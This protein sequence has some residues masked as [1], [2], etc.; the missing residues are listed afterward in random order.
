ML[1][2]ISHG[3]ASVQTGF[4]NKARKGKG[5]QQKVEPEPDFGEPLEEVYDKG[6]EWDYRKAKSQALKPAIEQVLGMKYAG[7]VSLC[8]TV[9]KLR[10]NKETGELGVRPQESCRRRWCPICEWRKSLKRWGILSE[11]LP[12]LIKQHGPVKWIFL[13]LT[14]RNCAVDDLPN[15]VSAMSKGFRNLTNNKTAL[16]RSWPGKAWIKSLE[17]TFPRPGE[18]HPHYHVLIAVKPS[19][20]KGGNYIPQKEWAERWQKAM[21][22]D[23]TPVVDVRRVKPLNQGN[24]SEADQQ[25]AEAM[26]GVREV[27]KYALEPVDIDAGNPEAIRGLASLTSYRFVDCGGWLKGVFR[28]PEND[29]Q[30][31]KPEMQNV[32]EFWWRA[33][34]MIYRRKLGK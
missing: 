21:R 22:L 20:F 8:A 12:G 2:T 32:S 19:Y 25:L 11:R 30:T 23:Y 33:A 7:E 6:S 10:R 9:V 17:V 15:T 26:G 31:D 5:G 4:L 24:S 3:Q 13:T 18:A 27:S 34:Q 16:G 14:V 29:D 28:D 1:G